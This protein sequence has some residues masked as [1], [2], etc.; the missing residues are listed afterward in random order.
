MLIFKI[1]FALILIAL[2]YH[3]ATRQYLNPY[4]LIMVFGKKGCGKSTTIAKLSLRYRKKGWTVYSTEDTPGTYKIDP[5]QIG[6]VQLQPHS[7]LFVDEV[8]MIWDNRQ[9]KNFRPEVRDFFKLQ[10]HYKVKVYLFSQ[11]FDIDKK[12]RDLTDEMYLLHNVFRVFSY[13]KRISK[14]I[15]LNKSTADSPSK[16]DEDLVFDNILWFWAGSRTITFI[17][18]YAKMFDS[19]KI[20]DLA[21][22]DFEQ[23]PVYVPVRKKWRLPLKWGKRCRAKRPR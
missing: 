10:R 4:K 3:F 20:K 11:T 8:G 6:Y 22:Y 21:R 1:A 9:F 16:I 14:N 19:Y 23:V 7:V 13:G 2:I 18:K 15:V 12:I 5:S 17:P